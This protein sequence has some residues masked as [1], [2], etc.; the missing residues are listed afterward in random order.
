[1]EYNSKKKSKGSSNEKS[2]LK[3]MFQKPRMKTE[4]S[5]KNETITK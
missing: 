4:S 5:P 2:L 3:Q 1:M